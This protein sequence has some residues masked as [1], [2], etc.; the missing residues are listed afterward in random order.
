MLN[1]GCHQLEAKEKERLRHWRTL[2]ERYGEE[3]VNLFLDL[4]EKLN[5]EQLRLFDEIKSQDF[6]ASAWIRKNLEEKL[7]DMELFERYTTEKFDQ[8]LIREP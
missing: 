6:S 7:K 8:P 5:L 2:I 3:N 1:M 4:V